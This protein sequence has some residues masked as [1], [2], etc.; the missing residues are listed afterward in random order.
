MDIIRARTVSR[1]QARRMHSRQQS[2]GSTTGNATNEDI[3]LPPSAPN[4]REANISARK[5]RD[6]PDKLDSNDDDLYADNVHHFDD[7]SSIAQQVLVEE[8]S[9][10]LEESRDSTISRGSSHKDNNSVGGGKKKIIMVPPKGP[11]PKRGSRRAS[12]NINSNSYEI[13]NRRAS[14]NYNGNSIEGKLIPKPQHSFPS[15][16]EEEERLRKVSEEYFDLEASKIVVED[17]VHN[18]DMDD[19]HVDDIHDNLG[20]EDNDSEFSYGN[21]ST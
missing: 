1:Q 11:P 7:S 8:T 14:N 6:S 9:G 3:P 17:N 10:L 5:F 12:G 21:N 4:S 13:S 2:A 20:D 18:N 19:I 15:Q 16:A